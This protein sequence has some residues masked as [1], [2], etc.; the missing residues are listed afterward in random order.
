LQLDSQYS[1]PLLVI[2]IIVSTRLSG[3]SAFLQTVAFSPAK[4][5]TPWYS[6]GKLAA[7]LSPDKAEAA[8]TVIAAAAAIEN[9][10]MNPPSWL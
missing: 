1:I 7:K 9:S 10:F 6:G 3:Q 5:H 2:D 4:F 8:I